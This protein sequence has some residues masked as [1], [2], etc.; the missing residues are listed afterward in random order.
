MIIERN[1]FIDNVLEKSNF[2]SQKI[3]DLWKS[4]LTFFS[5]LDIK[6]ASSSSLVQTYAQDS[7]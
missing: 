2:T 3:I 1:L 5:S 6:V 7:P 4:I